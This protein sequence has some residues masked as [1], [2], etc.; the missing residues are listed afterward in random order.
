MWDLLNQLYKNFGL[1]AL[2]GI[3]AV[4]MTIWLV[5]HTMASPCEKIS[6]FFGL[7]EYKK[8]GCKETAEAAVPNAPGT[9]LTRE[10]LTNRSWEFLHDEGDVISPRIRLNP[11][12]T[13]QGVDHPNESRW[14]LDDNT[15]V[16]YHQSGM[17]STRFT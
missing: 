9:P 14:N 13:I 6:I 2:F 10:F 17:P 5:A 3:A 4:F 8:A 11:S 1:R 16:F 12:G 15:L 7:I